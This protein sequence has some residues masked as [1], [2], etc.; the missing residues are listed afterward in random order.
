MGF[1]LNLFIVLDL[2]EGKLGVEGMYNRDRER[3]DNLTTMTF[4]YWSTA[5]GYAIGTAV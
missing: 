1:E 3:C 5:K 4:G 2:P